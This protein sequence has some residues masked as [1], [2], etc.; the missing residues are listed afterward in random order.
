MPGK[1]LD[2]VEEK[3]VEFFVTLSEFLLR[4]RLDGLCEFVEETLDRHVHH[5][6]TGMCLGCMVR[7][8]IEDVRLP[9]TRRRIDEKRVVGR[10]WRV[11]HASRRRRGEPVGRAHDKGLEGKS[12]IQVRRYHDSTPASSRY[13]VISCPVCTRF[14]VRRERKLKPHRFTTRGMLEGEPPRVQELSL[15]SLVQHFR[16]LPGLATHPALPA[17]TIY[18]ISDH[19]V[20]NMR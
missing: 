17:H 7:D 8:A 18:G 13:A 20:S 3:D 5:T 10:A 4:S 1:E 16:P 15:R 9:Q 14:Q 6:E 11:G 2:V 19:R 12:R